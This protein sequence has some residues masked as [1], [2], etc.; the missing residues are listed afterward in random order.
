MFW[1]AVY[2]EDMSFRVWLSLITAGLLALAVFLAWPEINQAFWYLGQVNLWILSLIIPIQLLNYLANGEAVFSYLRFKGKLKG[3]SPLRFIRI[4]LEFNFVNH[5]LPSGG[6]AGFAYFSWILKRYN[7]RPSQSIMAQIVRYGL[8]FLSFVMLLVLALLILVIDHTVGRG[9]ILLSLLLVFLV[10]AFTLAVIYLVGSKKRLKQFAAWLTTFVNKFVKKVTW[11]R[12]TCLLEAAT[13]PDFFDDIHQDYLDIRRDKNI[14]VKPFFW[15]TL[16]N[17]TNVVILYI[18]FLSFG[19]SINPALLMIA[20]CLSS[21]AAGISVIPGGI[22]VYET[23]MVV[24]LASA[25]ISAD[26][27]IAGALLAR[28]L[29]L[30]G[31]I[32]FG[33]IFYQLTVLK[34]GRV[35]LQRQ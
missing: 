10:L 28:I 24:F 29:I 4:A 1:L 15:A 9:A 2:N 30:S 14:I 12:K 33:Y 31:T 23:I 20:L 26:V 25:G 32:V 3:V 13:L 17:C 7:V 35:P 18:A 22:G 34:Y 19:V 16:A 21:I 11:G 27:A 5:I 8:T 6:A